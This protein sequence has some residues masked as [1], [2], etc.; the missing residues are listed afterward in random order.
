[1]EFLKLASQR[2]STRKYQDKKV[3][4]ELLNKI[5]E[6]G[7]IAPTASNKQ[8]QKLVVIQNTDSLKKLRKGVNFYN[9]SLA[10]IVCCDHENV[11]FKYS[12]DLWIDGSPYNNQP[13]SDIDAAIVADHMVLEAED[14]GLGSCWL[15]RFNPDILREEFLIPA[16]I[17][18]VIV[19][20]IGYAEIEKSSGN[21][22]KQRKPLGE[23][24]VCESF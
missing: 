4:Q 6:A 18:P 16:S 8:P 3:S 14:L 11:S 15:A 17:E 5:L 22:Q 7:R 9:A 13:T 23:I 19:L 2:C 10:I 20:A 1:M 12:R 24:M 21:Q